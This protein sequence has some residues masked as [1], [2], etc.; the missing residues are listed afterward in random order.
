MRIG[1]RIDAV[2]LGEHADEIIAALAAGSPSV[3]TVSGRPVG[4]VLPLPGPD[5]QNA[6]VGD[7]RFERW[8]RQDVVAAHDEYVADPGTAVSLEGFRESLAARRAEA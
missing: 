6:P 8:L 1:R 4:Q 7:E 5:E 3:L 2:E